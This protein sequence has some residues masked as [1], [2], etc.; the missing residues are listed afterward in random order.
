MLWLVWFQYFIMYTFVWEV[1]KTN[2]FVLLCLDCIPIYWVC[3]EE[4]F[5]WSL[6]QVLS[7]NVLD[8]RFHW[9][10]ETFQAKAQLC[11]L[12]LQSTGDQQL[13]LDTLFLDP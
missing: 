2:T 9:L 8:V 11:W 6:G 3:Q 7:P 5:S 10:A 13:V 4:V 1:F 12:A